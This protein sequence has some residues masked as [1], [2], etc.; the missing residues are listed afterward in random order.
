MKI[1]YIAALTLLISSVAFAGGMPLQ[2]RLVDDQTQRC[3]EKIKY[4]ETQHKQYP[5]DYYFKF[6]LNL[7]RERC[8]NT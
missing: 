3:L 4:F 7:W 6:M 5:N 8:K 2:K 1:K